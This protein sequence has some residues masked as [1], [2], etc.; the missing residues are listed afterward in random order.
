MSVLNL[1]TL[2]ATSDLKKLSFHS[3]GCGYLLLFFTPISFVAGCLRRRR[4]RLRRPPCSAVHHVSRKA[5]GGNGDQG[6]GL[7]LREGQDPSA[8]APESGQ[9]HQHRLPS[10]QRHEVLAKLLR[11][12]PARKNVLPLSGPSFQEGQAQVEDHQPGSIF[13]VLLHKPVFSGPML[14]LTRAEFKLCKSM[15]YFF[16]T[17]R[18]I[19]L[20]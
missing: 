10:L 11:E 15:C 17:V 6:Q 12:G 2:V 14:L 13:L 20:I 9:L 18:M 8:E 3:N 16:T 19:N 1:T 7:R 4:L 5:H